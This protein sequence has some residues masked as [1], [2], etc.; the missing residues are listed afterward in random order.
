MLQINIDPKEIQE[1]TRRL[2]LL[3]ARYAKNAMRRA[4]RRGAA[5]IRDT[6]RENAKRIDDPQTARKIWKN[7]AVVSGGSRSEQ[8]YGGLV[9]KVG[10]RG[11]AKSTKKGTKT[12][13]AGGNTTHWR[14][15]EYGTS[16][17]RAKAFFRPA[18][19][20]S[21][22]KAIQQIVKDMRA[23]LDKE[24]NKNL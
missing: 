24:L 12:S 22:E 3:K 9:I 16:R 4:L 2:E 18:F 17:A 6:A 7:L 10:V 15:I 19:Q 8:R 21:G 14:F 5:I 20:S 11:G 13:L 23:E 1:I